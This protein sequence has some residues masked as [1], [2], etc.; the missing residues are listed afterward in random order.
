LFSEKPESSMIDKK[1]IEPPEQMRAM[2]VLLP[3]MGGNIMTYRYPAKDWEKNGF[4]ILY[5]NPPGHGKSVGIFNFENT[6]T[7]LKKEIDSILDKHGDNLALIGIGH[8]GGGSS[9]LKLFDL[10][11]GYN[12]QKLFLLSPILDTA[13]SLHE[14]YSRNNIGEFIKSLQL[15]D[16][17][18]I[19]IIST[20]SWLDER[21]WKENDLKNRI[22]RYSEET[23]SG[24]KLGTFLENLFIPTKRVYSCLEHLHEKTVL[25]FPT[26][27]NWYPIEDGVRIAEKYDFPYFTI[28]KA[29]NH[30]F[31]NAWKDVSKKIESILLGD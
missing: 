2:I 7:L 3:C 14:L 19:E 24:S 16:S 4:G 25:F 1:L 10:N 21:Y 28:A 23:S 9:L 6:L 5:F 20:D 17:R 11:P 12:L 31:R 27:D 30:F 26:E 29:N 18:I 8:S 13:R 22:N 15:T